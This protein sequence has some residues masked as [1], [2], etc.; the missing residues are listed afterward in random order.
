ME[1]Y[2]EKHS[3]LHSTMDRHSIMYSCIFASRYI[4]KKYKS[5]GKEYNTFMNN[6]FAKNNFQV[7]SQNG[8]YCFLR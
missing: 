2:I 1:V 8:T 4:N 3:L 5:L 7:P 6:L